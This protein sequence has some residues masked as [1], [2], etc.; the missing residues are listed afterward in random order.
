M[1]AIDLRDAVR[2]AKATE[3][4]RLGSSKALYAATEGQ[5]EA[6]EVLR[7]AADA[8]LAAAE[9]FEAWAEAEPDDRAAAAFASTAEEERAHYETVL[10]ELDDHEPADGVPA[11]PAHLRGVEG[12]LPRSGALLG[13]VL[14]ADESK[15]QYVGY[16]V[17]NADPQTAGVFRELRS[18]LEVQ[19]ERA[20]ELL[21]EV[22]EAQDDWAAAESAATEAVAA[23]YEAHV[24]TLESLGVDPKPVC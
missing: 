12:T 18:D 3:L 5:L 21:E 22:C 13:R 16:F 23:A 2:E 1:S 24:E 15:S 17:G 6:E 14:V 7:A 20:L 19:E 9:T 10:A 11:L 4:S 8:E